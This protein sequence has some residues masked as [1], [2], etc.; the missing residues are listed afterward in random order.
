MYKR[1]NGNPRLS[2]E[3]ILDCLRS[4]FFLIGMAVAS[5]VWVI[6]PFIDA[7]IRDDGSFFQQ[8]V[9]PTAIEIYFRTAFLIATILLWLYASC[10]LNRA[11]KAEEEMRESKEQ[12]HSI[13]KSSTIAMIVA[14]DQ[15][16]T[17]V[18]WN[19]AAEK[20]FGY[21]KEDILGHPL[22]EIVPERY[23]DAHRKGFLRAA[24]TNNYRIMGQTVQVHG[25]KKNGEEFPIELSLGTWSR[26]SAKY[27][28]AIIHD[29]TERK[30]AIALLHENEAR[31]RGI[32][33]SMSDWVWE[34][35]TDN[36]YTYCSAKVE[37]VL[38]YKVAEL[39]GKTPF[40]IMP[41]NEVSRVKTR[42]SVIARYREP[43]HNL[44]N[45]RL[46]KDGRRV[47]CLT[48][49]VPITDDEGNFLGYR[50]VD[51]DI[52]ERK[53]TE[54]QLSYQA[55]H[56]ALT[57]LINRHEFERRVERLLSTTKEDKSEHA[58]C[59][60]D[61]DQFKVV[62]DTCGHVAG[63][64]ML[65]QLST[66]LQEAVRHRDTLARLGGDEFGIL[67][68]HCSLSDAHRVAKSIQ[69]AIQGYQFVWEGHSFK[70]G[71]SIG[72]VVITEATPSFT[73]LLIQADAACYVAKDLGRNRTHVYQAEDAS[74]AQHHGAMQ[75]VTRIQ[76]ALEEKRF[77]LYAQ[78]IVPLD[79][80]TD[81]HYELLV[82]MIGDKG[83]IILPDAFL[84][85]A[86]RY[87]LITN[88]DY[89]VVEKAFSLLIENPVFV[90]QIH[91]VSINLSG[92]SLADKAFHDFVIE[93]FESTKI[94]PDKICFEITETAAIGNLDMAN[95]FIKRMR[96]M[97]CRF[98]LDDF[99]SGLSSFGYLKNLPV[100]Y[101]KIDGMFVKD[102]VDD[103]VDHAM[104]RSIN[105][106]GQIT[107]IQT[108]AEF[109]E[110]EVIRGML[111]EMGVDYA[112][113]YGI[114]RP[115]PFEALLAQA[116]DVP[117]D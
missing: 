80:R 111:K 12:L 57:K 113:G 16:G 112:Q 114:G 64:T 7:V 2:R 81:K 27:F 73:R 116:D 102:I 60:L 74:L 51:T 15:S 96:F 56:D 21:D 77:C 19:T 34:I 23:R 17:I 49:G 3:E 11:R 76:R 63:D 48:S 85:T 30:Q 109:V 18:S 32:V 67:M 117:V 105:E 13:S 8:L 28:S 110:N 91:F 41:A 22:V 39:I 70:V 87:N 103:P 42:F 75:W 59:Y 40:D 62:N 58:M 107:E 43:F 25:L 10:L 5:L 36:A 72:L 4:R 38:G 50:G 101:L 35:D 115:I 88:L 53:S 82:R 95:V 89:W 99:G 24:K 84:P 106:V 83:E 37:T 71:V 65:R 52:T 14:V 33:E 98:A 61:L 45:W 90:D 93:L 97:G 104:V 55:S 31:F 47:C 6:D 86:E 9:Q 69:Q 54:E 26:G 92:P 20:I 66:V 29:I 108:I 100:D 44:E 94:P 78:A 1:S 46:S 79:N 68:E